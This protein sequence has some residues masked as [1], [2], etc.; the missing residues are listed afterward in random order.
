MLL[1]DVTHTTSFSRGR[2]LLRVVFYRDPISNQPARPTQHH[3][4]NERLFWH[5]AG[6]FIETKHDEET[7][8]QSVNF[9][10][11]KIKK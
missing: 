3:N 1:A 7:D 9:V 4:R 10:S 5:E 6:V 8:S 2:D 11:F